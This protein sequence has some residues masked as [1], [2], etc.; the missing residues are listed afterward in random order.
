MVKKHFLEMTAKEKFEYFKYSSFTYLKFNVEDYVKGFDDELLEL[1]LKDPYNSRLVNFFNN[2]GINPKEFFDKLSGGE[3]GLNSRQE[4]LLKTISVIGNN[5]ESAEIMKN[6]SDVERTNLSRFYSSYLEGVRSRGSSLYT[7]ATTLDSEMFKSVCANL[8]PLTEQELQHFISGIARVDGDIAP[9]HSKNIETFLNNDGIKNYII[10]NMDP[11]DF[12]HFAE[13]YNFGKE[14]ILQ[15]KLQKINILKNAK[16][17]SFDTVKN[18]LSDLMFKTNFNNASL[19]IQTLLNYANSNPE[20]KEHLGSLYDYL[21]MVNDVFTRETEPENYQK[22]IGEIVNNIMQEVDKLK[23]QEIDFYDVVQKELSVAKNAFYN[24][25]DKTL[26]DTQNTLLVGARMEYAEASGEKVPVYKI[27]KQTKNQEKFTILVHTQEARG[28]TPEEVKQ[29]YYDLRCNRTTICCS[30]LNE[31]HLSIFSSSSV[32]IGYSGFHGAELLSATTRDGQ[33]GQRLIAV[34]KDKKVYMQEYLTPEDYMNSCGK[35]H[36][37][38]AF[39]STARDE[40]GVL[41]PDYIVCFDAPT[42][43]DIISAK[44]FN[45]PII[46]IEREMYPRKEDTQ[47][48]GIKRPASK[49]YIYPE[50]DKPKTR[51]SAQSEFD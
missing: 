1:C 12:Y 5:S 50:F 30:I 15:R 42:E 23:S 48:T 45:I 32:C 43:R 26:Q 2:L 41:K 16:N 9:D 51:E 8:K 7:L 29:G 6:L 35:G 13:K 39:S 34:R 22:N 31:S 20:Y 25:M 19:D 27:A 47:E 14:A 18:A 21:T 10:K 38:L 4:K 17:M 24:D 44:A 46:Q 36:N 11:S 3:N 28:N 49:E 33:T 37:E 40:Y